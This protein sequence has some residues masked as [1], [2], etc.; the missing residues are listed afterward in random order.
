MTFPCG[1]GVTLGMERKVLKQC[2][3]VCSHCGETETILCYLRSG[4]VVGPFQIICECCLGGGD[5]EE[6]EESKEVEI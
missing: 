1:S 2:L 3:F 6:E 4:E 5:S